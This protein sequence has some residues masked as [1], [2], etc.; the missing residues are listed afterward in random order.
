MGIFYVGVV[1]SSA[2][3][4]S[5]FRTGRLGKLIVDAIAVQA[6]NDHHARVKVREANPDICSVC[7]GHTAKSAAI[8]QAKIE[9][10][11]L[12]QGISEPFSTVGVNSGW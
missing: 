5:H 9:S 4:W 7:G 2:D 10:W 12:R 6:D 3:S 11:S 8:E 1:R